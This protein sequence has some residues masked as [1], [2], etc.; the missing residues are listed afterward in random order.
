ML[1]RI[2]KVDLRE[3]W[4]R[5][6][7]DFSQWLADNLSYLSEELGMEIEII[8]TEAPIGRYSTDIL[9]LTAK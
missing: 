5:E 4:K 1:G 7:Q 2:K 3:I 9:W 6:P 8:R